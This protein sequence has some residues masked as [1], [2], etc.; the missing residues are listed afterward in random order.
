MITATGI[1]S[2]LDVSGIVAQLI[3]AEAAPQ[4]FLLDQREARIQAQI[5]GFGTLKSALLDLSNSLAGLKQESDFQ[6]RA[7]TSSDD[8]LFTAT[9][10]SD[11]ANATYSIVV[12]ALAQSRKLSSQGF[13]SSVATVA[14]AE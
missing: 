12:D 9:A 2:G 7:A 4:T 5:S 10:S 11:A 1:G 13:G 3:E 14:L 6:Q 8:T